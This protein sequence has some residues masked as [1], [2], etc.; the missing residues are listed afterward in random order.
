M[1]RSVK[2]ETALAC[3]SREGKVP[4]CPAGEKVLIGN[5]HDHFWPRPRSLTAPLARSLA[6]PPSLPPT[7]P[8]RARPISAH[9][10]VDK[11]WK[12]LPPS[13]PPSCWLAALPGAALRP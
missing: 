11:T 5:L 10:N 13:L 1:T 8:A 9:Y 12:C 4:A 7:P 2:C 3:G 6:P